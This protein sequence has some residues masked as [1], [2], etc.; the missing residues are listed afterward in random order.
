MTSS[1][2]GPAPRQRRAANW[3]HQPL[4][5]WWVLPLGVVVALWMLFR[6][7]VEPAGYVLAGTL[8]LAAVLRLALPREMV[9][10]LLV[11]SRAWDGLTLLALGVAVA[12][13]TASLPAG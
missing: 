13:A 5:L 3:G 4:G 7:G 1:S 6:G 11:R 2:A 12:V 8:A 9:G 10:G